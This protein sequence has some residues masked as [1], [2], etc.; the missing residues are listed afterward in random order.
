MCDRA[1]RSRADRVKITPAATISKLFGSRTTAINPGR[2]QGLLRHLRR[3]GR[4]GVSRRRGRRR[5]WRPCNFR[6]LRGRRPSC[7]RRGRHAL[8][9]GYWLGARRCILVIRLGRFGPPDRRRKPLQQ[10]HTTS[11]SSR[12]A[13]T[14]PENRIRLCACRHCGRSR[15]RHRH[16]VQALC[17]LEALTQLPGRRGQSPFCSADSKNGDSPRQLS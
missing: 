1:V 7:P 17:I 9:L 16:P 11:C 4:R 15:G 13:Q 6:R 5:R 8:L 10:I 12:A 2:S 14:S 3:T